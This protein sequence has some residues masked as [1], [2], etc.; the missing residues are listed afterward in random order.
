MWILKIGDLVKLKQKF[1][2]NRCSGILVAGSL[3]EI[4]GE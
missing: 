2:R 4:M 3:L 1:S